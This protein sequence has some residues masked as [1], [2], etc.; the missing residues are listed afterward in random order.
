LQTKDHGEAGFWQSLSFW[1]TLGLYDFMAGAAHYLMSAIPRDA[2]SVILIRD[3]GAGE[4]ALLIRRDASLAFA[5]GTW[6]FPGGKLEPTDLTSETLAKI[7]LADEAPHVAD[8]LAVDRQALGLVVAACRETFEE[9][10]IVLARRAN[11]AVCDSKIAEALQ[12]F[13]ARVT[14]DSGLFPALLADNGLAIE[15]ES[16]IRWSHWITPS[17]APKRFDAR[18]FVAVMPPGQPVRCDS[19]EATDLLWLDLRAGG[20]LPEPSLIPAPPTRFSLGDLAL[21][22]RKHGSVERLMRFE[23]ARH[24]VPMLPKILRIN[25]QMTALMPWD[26]EY[27]SSPG[28]G[29]PPETQIPGRYLDFPSRVAVSSAQAG[30]MLGG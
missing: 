7:G 6:V 15:S 24:V 18:F 21:C 9:T 10:G 11:G 2:A 17:I 4:Q 25:G 14:R 3:G 26:P 22:L 8:D 28:E 12:P 29:I 19:P 27:Q 16:L 5:G 1:L 23:A 13:R 20:P 30:G